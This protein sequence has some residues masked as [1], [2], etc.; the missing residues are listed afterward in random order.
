MYICD[1]DSVSFIVF[2]IIINFNIS[3]SSPDILKRASNLM[4]AILSKK[5]QNLFIKKFY[6]EI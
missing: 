4:L 2:D 5:F 6:V 3:S 1:F